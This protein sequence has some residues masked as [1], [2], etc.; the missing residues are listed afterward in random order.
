MKISNVMKKRRPL[1]LVMTRNRRWEDVKGNELSFNKC[2]EKEK[3]KCYS[4]SFME[5]ARYV[6]LTKTQKEDMFMQIDN[7]SSKRLETYSNIFE[8]IKEQLNDINQSILN[9]CK[10]EYVDN[11][12]VR[13]NTISYNDNNNINII[14]ERE[15][16]NFQSTD[17]SKIKKQIV[18][19]N[20]EEEHSDNK[21]NNSSILSYNDG[22]TID[23]NY[24]QTDNDIDTHHQEEHNKLTSFPQ[25]SNTKILLS[26]F[27]KS[28]IKTTT[29]DSKQLLSND[30]YNNKTSSCTSGCNNSMILNTSIGIKHNHD[31]F[32]AKDFYGEP[33]LTT[34]TKSKI[35]TYD[36]DNNNI[37][38]LGVNQIE[39]CNCF[40][41]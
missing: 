17:F 23:D 11:T 26:K 35:L 14:V 10:N 7:N 16:E 15:E 41:F 28:K 40:L 6:P 5:S 4:K 27:K 9:E 31:E 20:K 29:N 22:L 18:C 30:Y 39:Y 1:Q 24:N 25:C 2:E 12:E 38:I 8:Q 33:T 13:L 36:T 19:D 34:T 32:R 3:V 21:S 37:D